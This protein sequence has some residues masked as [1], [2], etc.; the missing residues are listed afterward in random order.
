MLALAV[1]AAWLV[2]LAAGFD[3]VISSRLNRQ[4]DDTV[5][6]RA[7]AASAT[8]GVRAGRVVAAGESST[9]GVLDSSIWVYAGDRA[10]E[11]PRLASSLLA[12]AD[13]LDRTR[14]RLVDRAGYRFYILPVHADGRLAGSVIAAVDLTPY[15][16]TRTTAWVGSIVVSVLLLAGAYPVL[17]FATGRALRPVAGMTRQA[18][19]WSVTAPGQRFGEDQQYVELSSLAGT[20]DELLDRLAAVLRHERHLSAEL[21]H[22]LRTPLARVVAQLDLL[23][24]NARPDQVSDLAAVAENC[25]TMDRIIETLLAAARSELTPRA[26]RCDVAAVF[27]SLS[28][29]PGRGL[30]SWTPTELGVGVDFEIVVRILTPVIDNARRFARSTVTLTA[31]RAGAGVA[32][33]VSNDGPRLPA[34]LTERVF[35]PGFRTDAGSD[36]HAGAGLG[37]AL[38]RRLARAADGDL[39]VD[40]DALHMTF[41]LVLPAG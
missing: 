24:E 6:V 38:A 27:R 23:I 12:V 2:V 4:V 19:V 41:R 32:V 17:R 28:S 7:Q 35:E 5:R 14:T 26:G 21:S 15:D 31:E 11:R 10:V 1:I 22:E 8:V 37:L 18:A 33:L 30:V 40:T 34:A 29:G 20:L 39:E 16:R 25:T 3:V 13:S 9:D 36:D